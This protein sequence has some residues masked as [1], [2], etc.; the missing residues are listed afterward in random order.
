MAR[1]ATIGHEVADVFF[2]RDGDG[3]QLSEDHLAELELAVTAAVEE[4]SAN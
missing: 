3:S 1:I 4:L 2:L